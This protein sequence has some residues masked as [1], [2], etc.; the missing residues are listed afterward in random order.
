MSAL[1]VQGNDEHVRQVEEILAAN[2]GALV[3]GRLTNLATTAGLKLPAL[4]KLK[5]LPG[6]REGKLR[7]PLTQG[8]NE[9]ATDANLSPGCV[10]IG[11]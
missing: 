1:D 4:K 9:K 8:T 11:S 2:G 5:L 7:N 10:L 6:F 3:W